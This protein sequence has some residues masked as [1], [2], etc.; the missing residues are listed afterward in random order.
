MKTTII[1]QYFP[2]MNQSVHGKARKSSVVN[3]LL[4]STLLIGCT[5]GSVDAQSLYSQNFDAS[6]AT[7]ASVGWTSGFGYSG[8]SSYTQAINN[9]GVGG[10]DAL[11][12]T[13]DVTDGSSLGAFVEYYTEGIT[14]PTG[15]NFS[16]ISLTADVTGNIT[17]AP[18]SFG[19]QDNN[20]DYITF[21]GTVS[22]AGVFQ[23]VGGLLN[24]ANSLN[25]S[26]NFASPYFKLDLTF[27]ASPAW[28]TGSDN[29]TIDNVAL[30]MVPEPSMWALLAVGSVGLFGW[31][32]FVRHA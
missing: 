15:A 7:P 1:S 29:L 19:I 18:F 14:F 20:S 32:R 6:G 27:G 23:S 31:R 25:S 17:G 13:V 24:T 10:S 9:T 2:F 22:N 12:T 4:T 28:T 8:E 26:F 5:V 11:V 30:T 3:A 16:N 21:N